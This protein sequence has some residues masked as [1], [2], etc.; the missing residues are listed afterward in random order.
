M[1]GSD[2]AVK[3]IIIVNKKKGHGGGHHGGAWKVAYADFVTAMMALFIV[4]W[5]TSSSEEVKKAVGGYFLDPSGKTKQMGSGVG[6][7]G[8]TLEVK[9]ADMNQLKDKIEQAIKQAAQFQKMKDQIQMTVTGE[10]L[11][12]EL[13]ETDKGMFFQSGRPE[14]T[15]MGRELLGK[16]AE[17]VGHLPNRI[18]IEGHTDSK[19]FNGDGGYSNWELSADRANAARRLME[20]SGLRAAQ[21]QQVR[22]FADQSL[23]VP[24]KPEDASNR[25]VSIIIK[26]DT[27]NETTPV[28][29]DAPDPKKPAGK[30]QDAQKAASAPNSRSAQQPGKPTAQPSATGSG[31]KPSPMPPPAKQTTK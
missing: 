22:G 30:N 16:L 7:T 26:Y 5:L 28:P 20:D 3:P 18:L 13:L 2:A 23:R 11:R 21:V 14:P 27:M 9:K 6:G 31:A 8:E 1:E 17:E 24:A 15:E 10:G 19:P 4:L 12:I 25:R 29:V